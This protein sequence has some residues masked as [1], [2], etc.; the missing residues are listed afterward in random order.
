MDEVEK[1]GRYEVLERIGVGSF[2]VVYRGRDSFSGKPVAI[3][4]C[5]AQ[6]EN[7]RTGFLRLAEASGR[8]QHPNIATVLEFGSGDGKPYLVEDYVEGE[9]LGWKIEGD[10]P[11]SMAQR[12]D[13]L[14]QIAEGL[15]YA[16]SRG[17]LHKSVSPRSIRISLDHEVK[18]TDFGIAQ[19]ASAT[20]RLTQGGPHTDGYLAPE[21]T[22]GLRADARTDIFC[23]GALAYELL[24][25]QRPFAA[26]TLADFLGQVLETGLEPSDDRLKGLPFG[27]R[28][29]IAQSLERDPADRYRNFDPL[30]AE[31]G[32]ILE[33][34]RSRERLAAREE[35]KAKGENPDATGGRALTNEDTQ[36]IPPGIITDKSPLDQQEDGDR[37]TAYFSDSAKLEAARKPPAPEKPSPKEK[38]SP[39]EK[40]SSEEKTSP[41]KK[42]TAGQSESLPQRAKVGPTKVQGTQTEATPEKPP[43]A[44]KPSD[45]VPVAPPAPASQGEAKAPPTKPDSGKMR[46]W[47]WAALLALPILGSL[48]FCSLQ[49][50]TPKPLPDPPVEQAAVPPPPPPREPEP[51]ALHGTLFIDALPWAEVTRLSDAAGQAVTLPANPVTPLQLPLPEGAYLVE[52]THPDAEG[53][54]KCEVEVFTGALAQCTA[55]FSRVA[56]TDYFKQTGWWQ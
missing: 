36:E 27:V 35:S 9:H 2:T 4:I 33:R 42:A 10:E 24:T 43:P 15:R 8:L 34:E 13:Y 7:L 41:S 52:L 44:I 14:L 53:T 32:P 39:K 45:S 12:L 23:F 20:S 6:E 5:I 50:G 37:T 1:I 18:I 19:L 30:L 21:Q 51:E 11:L 28:E 38:T 47:W 31:L 17:V 49:E 40:A 56:V 16:H 54:L 26:D 3:K 22:L 29:L 46:K 48:A 25:Y 55:E